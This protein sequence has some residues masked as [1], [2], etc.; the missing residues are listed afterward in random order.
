MKEEENKITSN[1]PGQ[2]RSEEELGLEGEGQSELIDFVKADYE[3]TKFNKPYR[4]LKSSPPPLTNETVHPAIKQH[5]EFIDYAQKYGDLPTN[6]PF[7]TFRGWVTVVHTEDEFGGY[8]GD[9]NELAAWAVRLDYH[10]PNSQLALLCT[11]HFTRLPQKPDGS[12]YRVFKL[13]ARNYGRF[14]KKDE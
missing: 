11:N 3:R 1:G 7:C 13:T 9:C 12:L 10:D 8:N 6:W 2:L 4:E 14:I 5:Q